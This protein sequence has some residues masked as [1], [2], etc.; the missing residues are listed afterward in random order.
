MRFHNFSFGSVQIDGS[1]CDHV[2]I[3]RGEIR[4]QKRPSMLFRD[5][6]G[7]AQNIPIELQRAPIFVTFNV[8]AEIL[9]T[10]TATSN[11]FPRLIPHKIA[12]LPAYPRDHFGLHA[13]ITAT[14]VTIR[15]L[16]AVLCALLSAAFA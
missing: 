13:Q 11:R 6:F 16:A 7:H 4:K 14:V 1:T 12:T 5:D 3:D 10:F 9:S 2:I 15:R 8:T